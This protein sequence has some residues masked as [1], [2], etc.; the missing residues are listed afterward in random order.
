MV[1]HRPHVHYPALMMLHCDQLFERL[2]AWAANQ[3]Q[4]IVDVQ[5]TPTPE[6]P[7][8]DDVIDG[9]FVIKGL[10]FPSQSFVQGGRPYGYAK[11]DDDAYFWVLVD[12]AFEALMTP[13]YDNGHA[14]KDASLVES[15]AKQANGAHLSIMF[16][17]PLSSQQFRVI[18]QQSSQFYG[19][20]TTWEPS[21]TTALV[22]I[23]SCRTLVL[24]KTLTLAGRQ[25]RRPVP[26]RRRTLHDG[27]EHKRGPFRGFRVSGNA[28]FS[29]G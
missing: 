3:P 13:W 15:M 1:E 23:T 29:V 10:N 17:A 28:C 26:R 8:A 18:R 5:P 4:S 24:L 16:D 25:S 7:L 27:S 12:D 11:T 21:D 19:D 6:D 20:P 9:Y 2:K 14:K 22:R